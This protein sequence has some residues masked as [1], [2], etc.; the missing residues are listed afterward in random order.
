[1]KNHRPGGSTAQARMPEQHA[2][3]ALRPKGAAHDVRH[4]STYSDNEKGHTSV[5]PFFILSQWE[6]VQKR[7]L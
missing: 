3:L 1:M 2:T 6:G 7:P 5:W 4:K